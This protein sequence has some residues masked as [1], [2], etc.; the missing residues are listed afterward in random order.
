MQESFFYKLF[1]ELQNW[2]RFFKNYFYENFIFELITI[3]SNLKKITCF[4]IFTPLIYWG[5]KAQILVVVLFSIYYIIL[6]VM[7]FFIKTNY[8]IKCEE[9]PFNGDY[10]TRYS[11]YHV[12]VAIPQAK[13]Y[14]LVYNIMYV[15]FNKDSLARVTFSYW[16]II[17]MCILPLFI[18]KI[19]VYLMVGVSY[20]SIQ[21]SSKMIN[22]A[23]GLLK[24][25]YE[26]NKALYQTILINCIITFSH[27]ISDAEEKKIIFKNQTIFF[28]M[29][30]VLANFSKNT[31]DVHKLYEAYN[32][33][34]NNE[35]DIIKINNHIAF[36]QSSYKY[37]DK[38]IT[39][40]LTHS[41]ELTIINEETGN[42]EKVC[43]IKSYKPDF[44]GND[45][46]NY[47]TKPYE[48]DM[49]DNYVRGWSGEYQPK[50]NDYSKSAHNYLLESKN[51]PMLYLSKS[52]FTKKESSPS[53]YEY[54][55]D[56]KLKIAIKIKL[57]KE[58]EEENQE[59]LSTPIGKHEYDI[60]KKIMDPLLKLKKNNDVLF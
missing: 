25:N 22:K 56:C 4:L 6:F 50:L 1:K 52:I 46:Y 30:G 9:L 3:F 60:F 36:H 15:L 27:S 32:L 11:L 48:L 17:F 45:D 35:I 16:I 12:F 31:K 54:A 24:W 14:I 26:S 43:L 40:N 51:E 39:V 37:N 19:Y 23:F 20:L 53:L 29:K 28:N 5:V 49:K 18:I 41:E 33:S 10:L 58:F 34:K 7:L 59:Y 42:E 2:F 44:K 38:N 55:T 57:I 8:T 47:F 21:V 13:G